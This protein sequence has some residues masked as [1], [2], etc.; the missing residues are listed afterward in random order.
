VVEDE[1][2]LRLLARRVLENAGYR[3]LEAVNG[4]DAE[5]IFAQH[6][7][8]IALVVADVVMPGCGGPELMGR[9]HVH[10]PALRVLYMSGYTEH[11]AALKLGIDQGLMFVQKP[12]TAAELVMRVQEVLN[13]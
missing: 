1:S 6:A 10:A 8:S 13:P 12:F 7:D 11:S 9:L 3:V 5:K 4:D 2:G